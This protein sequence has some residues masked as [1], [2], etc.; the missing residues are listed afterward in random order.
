MKAKR[1]VS[2][3]LASV[4]IFTTATAVTARTE[5][6]TCKYF[7]ETGHYVCGP[8]LEYFRAKGGLEIFGYPL[9]EAF[10]DPTHGGLRVQYFQRARMEL[11]PDGAGGYRVLLGLLIDE[12]GY[13]FPPIGADQIPSSNDDTQ[14]YFPETKHVVS[15]AFLRAFREKGGLEIFGYPRSEFIYENGTIVQYFQRARMEWHPDRA[16]SSQIVLSNVGELYL[17]RFGV[18]GDYDEPAP[19]PNRSQATSKAAPVDT[20]RCEYF[21]ETG[22][23]VCDHF[24]DYYRAK[25]GKEIFGNPLTKPFSD[26]KHGGLRVQYFERARMELHPSADGGYHVLLGL[27]V[28]ELGF[29]FPPVAPDQIPAANTAR[30]HYF[31]E[32]KHVVSHAFLAAFREMGGLELFGYPRSELLYEDG[33]IVQYFQRARMEWRPKKRVGSL[34]QLTDLGELYLERFP[35][36][37]DYREPVAG[38][39]SAGS[40]ASGHAGQTGILTLEVSASVKHPIIGPQGTQTVFVHVTDQRGQPVAGAEVAAVVSYPGRESGLQFSPTNDRGFTKASFDLFP[41]P[42]GQK[43]VVEVAARYDN[44]SKETQTSFLRW[45]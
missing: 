38:P 23:R 31:P 40:A 15:H 10:D 30:H 12:L 34:I 4:I 20:G 16:P 35:V 26:P 7:D 36:P 21:A 27:L 3:L 8:Y 28:D 33:H 25:G 42:P 1:L 22:H 32:T 41:S 14:H 43:V 18:P 5:P 9:T 11:H 44:L 13:S 39:G 24:L 37:E 2:L 17:E 6:E 45:H 29:T 19:P